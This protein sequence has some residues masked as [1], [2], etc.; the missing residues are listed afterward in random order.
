MNGKNIMNNIGILV[1]FSFTENDNTKQK[2]FVG[3]KEI[4]YNGNIICKFP[5][6]DSANISWTYVPLHALNMSDN[7][8]HEL[9]KL[10]NHITNISKPII[11]NIT[12][13]VKE[14]FE[15]KQVH[16]SKYKSDKI[17]ASENDFIKKSI[18]VAC[19]NN[20]SSCSACSACSRAFMKG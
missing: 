11:Q 1:R 6:N 4:E 10:I 12:E 18:G 16:K 8:E 5:D 13:Y 19:S 7:S 15:A 3:L 20:C 14:E 9:T 2:T 17:V